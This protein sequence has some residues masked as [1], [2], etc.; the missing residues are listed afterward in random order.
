M[1][2]PI[3]QYPKCY[4]VYTDGSD[5]ACGAQLS[6]EHNDQEF[7]VAFLSHM[8]TDTQLKWSTPEQ[9][10][11]GVYYGVM[12]WKY[13]LHGSEIVVHNDHKPVQNFLSGKNADNKVNRW[14]LELATHNITFEWMSG[15][16]NKAANCLSQLVNVKETP[17]TSN[18]S[19]NMVVT[20]TTDGPANH[21]HSKTLTDTTP[22]ADVKCSLN[23][24]KVS[25]PLPPTEDYKDTLFD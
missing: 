25:A 14:S 24:D 9:E 3:L 18:T 1:V 2:V 8:F 5:D 7:P 17:V 15:A 10:A 22:P 21:S 13:Y 20:Y 4:M 6:Q 16:H 23:T 19:I 12:K 11:Y